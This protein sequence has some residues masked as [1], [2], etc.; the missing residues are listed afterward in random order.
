MCPPCLNIFKLALIIA[1]P[2]LLSHSKEKKSL[3][4]PTFLFK[5]VLT[6]PPACPLAKRI[7]LALTPPPPPPPT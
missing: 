3:D 7:K 4:P 2:E 6:P 1:L 5:I